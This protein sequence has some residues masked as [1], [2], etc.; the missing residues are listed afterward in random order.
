M[1]VE[2]CT[3]CK[4]PL[5]ANISQSEKNPGRPF[6]SCPNNCKNNFRWLP[7]GIEIVSS[8]PPKP[9][10]S[11]TTKMM[12]A[13]ETPTKP[14]MFNPKVSEQP[15]VIS[16]PS[17]SAGFFPPADETGNNV[18]MMCNSITMLISSIDSLVAEMSRANNLSGSNIVRLTNQLLTINKRVEMLENAQ[19]RI[20][21]DE[22][23]NN[24]ATIGSTSK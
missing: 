13:Q 8:A 4:G 11:I 9:L 20:D 22:E 6:I 15:K 3:V 10:S 17:F 16:S 21:M 24:G 1:N 18:L 19:E 23:I 14:V 12:E 7:T 5:K 2:Q